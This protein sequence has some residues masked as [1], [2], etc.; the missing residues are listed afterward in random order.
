MRFYSNKKSIRASNK[1]R[2]W[3]EW[4]L[5]EAPSRLWK[6]PPTSESCKPAYRANVPCLPELKNSSGAFAAFAAFVAWQSCESGQS[7]QWGF[8]DAALPFSQPKSISTKENTTEV[9]ARRRIIT[10]MHG[11]HFRTPKVGFF[12]PGV[13]DKPH[14]V[15]YVWAT[16]RPTAQ[17][18][19]VT[20][21]WTPYSFK[22]FTAYFPWTSSNILPWVPTN[23]LSWPCY[24]I[25]LWITVHIH[26]HPRCPAIFAA[27][28]VCFALSPTKDCCQR[29]FSA[30]QEKKAFRF[31]LLAKSQEERKTRQT[32]TL[33]TMLCDW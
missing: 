31:R 4:H 25:S 28:I 19:S 9:F 30:K 14:T 24:I 5:G 10:L 29:W 32:S 3:E 22:H 27:G 17:F 21:M 23:Y 13:F 11:S 26:K 7:R 16:G 33:T 12:H 8:A 1:S 2:T 15:G 20:Y 18:A 6:L